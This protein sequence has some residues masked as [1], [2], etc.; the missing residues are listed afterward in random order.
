[1]AGQL[2]DPPELSQHAKRGDPGMGDWPG[3]VVTR[4]AI[5]RAAGD[6]RDWFRYGHRESAAGK[7]WRE[8]AD[9][10]N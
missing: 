5:M 10:R 4:E 3:T 9:A 8:F 1:M 2:Y 7:T 6:P